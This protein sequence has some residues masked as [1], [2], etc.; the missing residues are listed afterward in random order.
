MIAVRRLN[1]S[2]YVLNADFIETLEA[3]PDTVITLKNGKKMVVRDS[4]EE[5]VRKAIKYKQLCNQSIQVVH[6]KEEEVLD[7]GDAQRNR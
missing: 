5:I 7:K 2:E 3:T 1:N 4:I 6:R